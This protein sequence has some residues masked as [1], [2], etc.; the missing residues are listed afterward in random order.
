[1]APGEGVARAGG[2]EDILLENPLR[3]RVSKFRRP[4]GLGEPAD[5][6]RGG[7][8]ASRCPSCRSA[9]APAVLDDHVAEFAPQ[10]ADTAIQAAAENDAA[11]ARAEGQHDERPD[12][13]RGAAAYSP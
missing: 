8:V 3:S 10:V 7:G 1:M 12:L 4:P 11:D 2:V 5:H 6:G 13:L 9:L